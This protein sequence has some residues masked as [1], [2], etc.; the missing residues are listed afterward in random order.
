MSDCAHSCPYA[1]RITK[2]ETQYDYI[3]PLMNKMDNKLDKVIVGLGRVELLEL[4]H[5]NHS[6]SIDR[7]FTRIEL[8]EKQVES[9][10]KVLSDLLSQIKGMTRLAMVLWA[11]T[12]ATVIYL[13]NKVL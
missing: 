3:T 6:E 9:T 4:K 5:S 12:G 2:L 1:G 13:F 11:G 7:A 8:V 10:A